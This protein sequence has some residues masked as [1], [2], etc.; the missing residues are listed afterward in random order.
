M[1]HQNYFNMVIVQEETL[2]YF[3][4]LF[5]KAKQV[6]FD[7]ETSGL[8]VR[9]TGKDY[10]VGYTFAFEDDVSKDVYYIPVRHVFEGTFAEEDRFKHLDSK[11]LKSFPNFFP[12]KFAGAY[13][14]VDAYEFAQKL[15]PIMESG[16]KE[17]IAHNISYDLHVIANEGVDIVYFFDRNVIQDTQVMVH[18]IDENVEKN[19]EA[20]TEMLFKVKK[21]HYSDTI[22]TVT[23]SEKLSQGMKASVNASFQHVQIPI[24]G[25]YSCEDVWFM[26]QMYPKLIQGLQDDGQYDMYVNYRIPFLKVLW[27]M[28][29]KGVKVDAKALDNMQV[30]A[31]Y[32]ADNF[33]YRMYQLVGIEFNPDSPQQLYEILFGFWTPKKAIKAEYVAKYEEEYAQARDPYEKQLIRKYYLS[34]PATSEIVYTG[35]SELIGRNLGFTPI[36]WTDGGKG[37]DDLKRPKTGS[38]VLEALLE[39]D[40]SEK[41]KQFI[42]ELVNYKKLSKLIS[43]FMIGLREQIYEDGKVHCNFNLC[44]TDSWRLSSSEPK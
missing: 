25:Q 16:G 4:S 42:K 7:T 15:K 1:F 21:S 29:R 41:A 14:N 8:A 19:L 44:G 28:E 5:Q 38:K 23:K 17:Y 40:V 24:G 35:N 13:Y 33:K 11:F 9:H 18:T 34:N 12:K 32:E 20:V 22:K 10:V 30:Q 26:K 37:G 6:F 3:F 39:Q 36:E 43:A 2:D 31:S 27:K